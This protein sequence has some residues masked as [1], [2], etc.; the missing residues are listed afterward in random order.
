MALKSSDV[1][2]FTR[3][4]N[5]KKLLMQFLI[6]LSLFGSLFYYIPSLFSDD[7]ELLPYDSYRPPWMS[8]KVLVVYQFIILL[9]SV[10]PSLLSTMILMMTLCTL[11][12]LQF[13]LLNI[14]IERTLNMGTGLSKYNVK[15]MFKNHNFLLE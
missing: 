5:R 2:Y 4:Y 10:V 13:R 9:I 7:E 12:Q 1:K 15:R 11:T 8:Y 3:R 14:Q 6:F